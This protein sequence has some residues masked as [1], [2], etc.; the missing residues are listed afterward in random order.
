[1]Q[2]ARGEKESH[3]L[4]GMKQNGPRQTYLHISTPTNL[5]CASLWQETTT[6]IKQY[7]KTEIKNIT[8]NAYAAFLSAIT[9]KC[10]RV[11]LSRTSVYFVI[12]QLIL[13]FSYSFHVPCII[14]PNVYSYTVRSIFPFLFNRSQS[15]ASIVNQ[16]SHLFFETQKYFFA[17]F[18]FL[19][20]FLDKT[21]F[22]RWSTLWNWTFKITTLFWRCLMFLIS[23]LK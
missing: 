6:S 1:M 10:G 15:K 3:L 22:R 13:L 9:Y 8:D 20:M 11:V 12:S 16:M 19:K 2:W 17:L 4:T 5:Q 18:N 14:L 23:T 21:L 7:G